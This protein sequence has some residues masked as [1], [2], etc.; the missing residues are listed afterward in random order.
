MKVRTPHVADTDTAR[1]KLKLLEDTCLP[2]ISGC[3]DIVASENS[4]TY[5]ELW[6]T[7]KGLQHS[8]RED[9]SGSSF[10]TTFPISPVSGVS[11]AAQVIRLLEGKGADYWYS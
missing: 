8:T 4:H 11:L 6:N 5:I 7:Q 9:T 2:H 3:D 1:W 10:P